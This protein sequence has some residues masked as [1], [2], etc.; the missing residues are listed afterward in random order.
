MLGNGVL[1]ASS[2]PVFFQQGSFTAPPVTVAAA[3]STGWP[4]ASF[5]VTNEQPTSV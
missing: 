2:T 3:K 4:T 1:Q 5:I